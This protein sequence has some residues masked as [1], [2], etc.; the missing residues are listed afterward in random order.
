MITFSKLK[1]EASHHLE[2]KLLST[3]T[4]TEK[5]LCWCFFYDKILSSSSWIELSRNSEMERR[6]TTTTKKSI[7]TIDN[8]HHNQH[9]KN[10]FFYKNNNKQN[11]QTNQSQCLV[12]SFVS[13]NFFSFSF[14]YHHHYKR[15]SLIDTYVCW[16]LWKL[17]RLPPSY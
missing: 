9:K 6:T 3:K 1:K 14:D 2:M 17:F 12:F 5:I 4:K 15:Q 13:T 11:Y 7:I 10:F 16:W 8:H